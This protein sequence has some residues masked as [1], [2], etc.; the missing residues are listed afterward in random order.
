ML[1]VGCSIKSKSLN[2]KNIKF[3]N[4]CCNRLELRGLV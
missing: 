4:S 3:P 2:F 1:T